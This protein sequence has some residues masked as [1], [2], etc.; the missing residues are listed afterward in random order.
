MSEHIAPH[1]EAILME[2]ADWHNLPPETAEFLGL[3]TAA[4]K[5][6]DKKII[7]KCL[8]AAYQLGRAEG[9]YEMANNR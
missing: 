4:C 3:F 1:L 7:L 9:I 2:W 8:L 5:N 6:A